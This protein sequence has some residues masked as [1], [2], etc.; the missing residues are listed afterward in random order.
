[1]VDA[2]DQIR[3][4]GAGG[5]A[6]PSGESLDSRLR[7]EAMSWLAVR[8]NDGAE[9]LYW[10][11]FEDFHFDG[12]PFKLRDRYKG[13]WKPRQLEAAL[14]FST[15]YR[16][17]GASRPYEDV[18]GPDGLFRYKWQGDS[19]SHADNRA[20]RAARERGLPLIWFVAVRQGW[21][22]PVF[23]VFLVAEEPEQQQFVVDLD[24]MQA[25]VGGLQIE[26]NFPLT[27]EKR[28]INRNVKS[29]LHQGMF[30][31]DVMRAYATKCAVCN[32][33][34]RELLDAAHIVPDSMEGGIASVVNGLALCKIHHAAF[35]VN[36]MGIR[37]DHVVEIRS[38]LLDE[39]D[40]PMLQY[41]LKERH[42]KPLM[43]VPAR[44]ADLP[45]TDLLEAAYE[46]FRTAG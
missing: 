14:S 31:A 6:K 39:I 41:G 34:H 15:T 44:R 17:T 25:S 10:Q 7:R 9:A 12:E 5:M 38:D 40:G 2:A 19:Y 28:Y 4:I 32:L 46:R 1:M 42:N 13:I 35:D 20:M 29:R 11:D 36:I 33:K 8:T 24:P 27:L 30:R 23:P 22:L 45:S 37:A 3:S 21:Y 16:P 43:N 26:V 18:T